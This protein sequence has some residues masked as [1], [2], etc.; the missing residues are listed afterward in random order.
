MMDSRWITDLNIKGK[1]VKLIEENLEDYLEI[2]LKKQR[3]KS[4]E[5][6]L[7]NL[8]TSR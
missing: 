4:K 3:H 8:I 5:K 1:N 2:S 6:I 7:I